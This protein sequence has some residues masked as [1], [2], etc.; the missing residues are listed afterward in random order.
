MPAD[1]FFCPRAPP[2]APQQRAIST[3]AQCR[4]KNPRHARVQKRRVASTPQSKTTHNSRSM[5]QQK[6]APRAAKALRSPSRPSRRAR[7]RRR[8]RA[9][10]KFLNR[11]NISRRRTT[12]SKSASVRSS[13]PRA[14]RRATTSTG[15]SGSRRARRRRPPW[16]RRSCARRA[17]PR[18]G[19]ARR[20]TARTSGARTSPRGR[21]SS[22]PGGATT[23]SR[24]GRGAGAAD[25]ADGLARDGGARRQTGATEAEAARDVRRRVSRRVACVDGFQVLCVAGKAAAAKASRF[26][27]SK[28]VY[29]IYFGAVASGAPRG[30]SS[31]AG[32]HISGAW[33]RRFG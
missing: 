6:A 13:W 28:D 15:T 30:S 27:L 16:R 32:L 25:D 7:P 31:R 26:G 3:C 23:R 21:S 9:Q 19:S 12:A 2:R 1:F 17:R 24:S 22:Q 29:V 18:R 5:S 33:L 4:R 11:C 8:R 14:A 10:R 20:R